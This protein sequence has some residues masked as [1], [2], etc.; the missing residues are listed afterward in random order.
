[1]EDPNSI[2]PKQDKSTSEQRNKPSDSQQ[3]DDKIRWLLV[4]CA[5]AYIPLAYFVYIITRDIAVL[6]GSTIIGIIATLVYTY[7]FKRQKD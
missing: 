7:Y 4:R 1:V 5:V 6:L 2:Q 3:N